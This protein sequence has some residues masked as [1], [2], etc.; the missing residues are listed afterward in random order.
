MVN[1]QRAT[2]QVTPTNKVFVLGGDET[3][4]QFNCSF[5]YTSLNFTLTGW[6]RQTE[7]P[8]VGTL[9]SRNNT[10]SYTRDYD[11]VGN[12]NLL[13]KNVGT[14]DALYYDCQVALAEG[15]SIS[16]LAYLMVFGN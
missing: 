14:F 13:I 1:G 8:G 12:Y 16:A 15:Y 5:D 3:D 9:L 11:I 7:S 10:S 4:I 2:F 6:L